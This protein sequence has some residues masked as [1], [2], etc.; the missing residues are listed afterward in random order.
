MC[1][2]WSLCDLITNA[3]INGGIESSRHF[4]ISK[5]WTSIQYLSWSNSSLHAG[6]SDLL[7][8][9]KESLINMGRSMLNSIPNTFY[10][11]C[12]LVSCFQDKSKTFSCLYVFRLQMGFSGCHGKTSSSTSGHFMSVEYIHQRWGTQSVASGVAQ[13]LVAAKTLTPGTWT[14]NFI[15]RQSEQMP[16]CLSTF[17]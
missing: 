9:Y 17:L 15:W 7:F 11:I 8:V 4:L 1:P 5:R 13:L 12:I 10:P 14:P 16:V 2:V 6:V 3:S